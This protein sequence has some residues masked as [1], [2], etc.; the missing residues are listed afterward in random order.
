MRL[1]RQLSA[2][3][4]LLTVLHA[5]LLAV[6]LTAWETHARKKMLPEALISVEV[7]LLGL[8]EPSVL[9]RCKGMSGNKWCCN[10]GA[11]MWAPLQCAK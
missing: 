10:R 3:V 9:L 7:S 11:L 6:L 4:L 1:L 8:E 2:G 5:V